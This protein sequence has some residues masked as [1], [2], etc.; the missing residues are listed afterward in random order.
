MSKA[1]KNITKLNNIVSVTDFYAN[2]VSGALVDPTGVID[3]SLGF[4]AATNALAV[5]GGVVLIPKGIYLVSI[6]IKTYGNVTI[7]GEGD[8]SQILVNTDIEVFYSDRT[9]ISIAIYRA[10]F[11]NFYIK[12]TVTTA[13]T[14]YDIHLQNPC[15][16]KLSNVRI[17]SGHVDSVYSSTNVGGV[18]LDKPTGAVSASFMN[19]IED[20]WIQNNSIYFL[21]VTDSSVTGG[22][23]WGH[24]RQF[25]IRISGASSGNIDIS[26]SKGIITS[27]YNGGIW[28]DGLGINQIRIVD[29]E[30]D[31]NPLLIRGDGIY[32][33]QQTE[34]VTVTGNTFW[35]CGKNGINTTDPVGWT[36][37]GNNFW[38]NNDS[39][40]SY[41]DVRI[42]GATFQPNGNTVTGN[43]HVMDTARVNKGYA[44]REVNA[45][46]NPISNTYSSNGVL[47]ATGY[48]NPAILVLQQATVVGNSGMGTD[49]ILRLLGDSV[50]LDSE[51]IIVKT[52]RTTVTAISGTLDLLLTT[53]T[54]SGAQGS[55]VGTL[56]VNSSRPDYPAQGRKVV[57]ALMGYGTTLVATQLGIQDGTGGG[58]T[59]TITAP[60]NGVVRFTNTFANACVVDMM[61]VGTRGLAGA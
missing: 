53:E 12:K 15:V 43:V 60:N 38:K 35:G 51:A 41:D 19:R 57:Y 44:I 10:E 4:Q 32:S 31:G 58:S 56:Y 23:V 27:Q 14:K 11:Y 37:T 3:S 16:C 5:S 47:G 45:G 7:R 61:F 34:T 30:W 49:A 17:Q 29:N 48:M 20:C 59:F 36:V 42:I 39:D 40:N 33:P 24:V 46:Y 52:P 8:A 26:G 13:T 9:T 28:L 54:Y 25:A 22:F 55:Y 50:K 18:F 1:L 21:N 6:P 2:G